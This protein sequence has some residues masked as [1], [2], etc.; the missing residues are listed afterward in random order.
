VIAGDGGA[1]VDPRNIPL[2]IAGAGDGAY[3]AVA[4][5]ATLWTF[6]TH[7]APNHHEF[8][9][10]FTPQLTAMT[11]WSAL[12]VGLPCNPCDTVGRLWTAI[13]TVLNHN[14]PL[15]FQVAKNFALNGIAPEAQTPPEG[16]GL[17]PL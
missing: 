9:T 2:S 17:T 7:G 8:V 14:D 4:V 6:I 15:L 12:T 16:A 5:L 10:A 13:A 3:D 11:M 1:I